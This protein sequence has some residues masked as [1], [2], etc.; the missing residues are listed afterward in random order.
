MK[1]IYEFIQLA[2]SEFPINVLCKYFKISRSAYY[3]FKTGQTHQPSAV[4]VGQLAQAKEAF[5]VHKRRYGARRLVS[6]LQDMGLRVGR[7]KVRNLM[8]EQGL[9]AIQPKSFIPR[10][11]DSRH[12]KRV[13]PNLLLEARFP[14]NPNLVWVGDMDLRQ[15]LH[16]GPPTYP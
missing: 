11:T 15:S 3:A 14:T 13:A 16:P 10:T 4:H 9:I 8:N 6:E 7:K 12:G 2:E 1:L 5:Q